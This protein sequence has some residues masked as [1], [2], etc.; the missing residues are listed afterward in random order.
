MPANSAGRIAVGLDVRGEAGQ[1]VAPPTLHASGR[2]YEWTR[3]IAPAALP[4]WLYRLIATQGGARSMT[5][6][7]TV[8]VVPIDPATNEGS[9]RTAAFV[10]ECRGESGS[11]RPAI[12]GKGGHNALFHAACRGALHYVLR[13]RDVAAILLEH[14][15]PRCEPPWTVHDVDRKVR[16]VLRTNDEPRFGPAPAG[17]GNA[18]IAMCPPAAPLAASGSTHDRSDLGN[19]AQLVRLFGDSLRYVASWGKFL[20]WDGRRWVHD[21]A[22][23]VR[24]AADTARW[25]LADATTAQARATEALGGA[26]AARD[27]D[28]IKRC[29]AAHGLARARVD[30][31]I[32]SQDAKRIH[33]MA[34]LV[35]ADQA[36]AVNH[37]ALDSDAWLLNVE[38]GT[39]NLRTAKLG[40]HDPRDLITRL[41]PVRF[42]PDATCPS[43]DRFLAS[44]MGDD[45]LIAYLTRLAGYCLTGDI[46]EHC[47]GFNF[48][49]GGNGKSTFTG[50]MVTL[51]GD[52]AT[53]APRTLLFRTRGEQHPTEIAS[54]VGARFVVCA[55][56]GEG[57]AFDEPK[58]KDLTGGDLISAR[59]M[60]EDFWKF[61]PTH[62]LIIN[63]NH[64]PR[65]SGTD[66]G[67][68]RRIRLVPWTVT[69][70]A[71]DRDTELPSKLAN[72]L[73][74]ILAWAVRGCL[75][76]QRIGLGEPIKVRDATEAYREES[77]DVAEF[78]RLRCLLRPGEK[79]ARKVL[80]AEYA[81]FCDENGAKPLDA[82]AFAGR[83][84]ERGVGDGGA[85]TIN[86]RKC[87]AWRGIRLRT[88]AER[89]ATDEGGTKR[90]HSGS[91]LRENGI[92]KGPI[93]SGPSTS[94]LR[95]ALV[96]GGG[97]T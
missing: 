81:A 51:L 28:E 75:E 78:L 71:E 63:G 83:L 41:V 18:L 57:Q 56:V 94:L 34:S 38:N 44:S 61:R 30:W 92:P 9:A 52:Y 33:A 88:D 16:E 86:G 85:I 7:P 69:I 4:E 80:R 13:E 12:S 6:N 64:K 14:Y 55:E 60:N 84:R 65:V 53:P 32:K 10:S 5:S 95:L 8:P 26:R 29:T 79:S 37:T 74:G 96:H 21:D 11:L 89:E 40:A 24:A 76:W 59:R 82:R 68:W 27:E 1:I 49:G 72:E 93:E 67:I 50:A 15:N 47:L 46:R 25:L 54:L 19:V 17:W 43:W 45:D 77:D 87:D 62:K 23:A 58:V 73:P 39:I 36:I 70:P 90:D 3:M 2:R 48:G 66:A 20:R 22:A 35:R 42:D 97:T 91:I 31:A